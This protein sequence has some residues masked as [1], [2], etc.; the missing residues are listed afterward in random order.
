MKK[1]TLLLAILSC[2]LTF[3]Q[4]KTFNYNQKLTYTLDLQRED[5]KDIDYNVKLIN[6]YSNESLFGSLELQSPWIESSKESFISLNN[7][8]YDVESNSIENIITI[9]SNYNA[10]E[11]PKEDAKPYSTSFFGDIDKVSP[12]NTTST[13]NNYTC[14]N[15]DIVYKQTVTDEGYSFEKGKD[16]IC[17]DEKNAI[18]NINFLLP[19]HNLKG[20]LVFLKNEGNGITLNLSNIEKTNVTLT[21]DEKGETE[22]Y[23]VNIEKAKKEYEDLL[24]S[25][26]A[27]TE[28]TDLTM[29]DYPYVE[30]NT[31]QHPFCN[32][33]T[34]YSD[35]EN[36]PDAIYQIYNES[37]SELYNENLDYKKYMKSAKKLINEKINFYQ[38]MDLIT[39][40]E[41]KLIQ[42]VNKKLF[43]D[44]ESFKITKVESP[45]VD[46]NLYDTA[47]PVESYPEEAIAGE[48]YE[49]NYKSVN[50]DPISLAMEATDIYK[51]YIPNYCKKLEVPAFTNKEFSLHVKN[52]FGQICDLYAIP[53]D[54][55]VAIKETIDSMR[56]SFLKI[57]ELKEKQTKQDQTLFDQYINNLD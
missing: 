4:Q 7:R 28:A 21:F 3:A 24:N 39:K 13:Y 44:A 45:V 10:W 48:I 47:E 41:K 46:P 17:V 1:Y 56:K 36:A 22:R 40:D 2:S 50:I 55:N 33:H 30:S 34:Y 32:F 25:T 19:N 29:E 31:Y 6:Y 23:F 12:L 57:N 15:Y 8:L 42:N 14:K 18:N 49:S 52:Y 38:A 16:I 26:E 54:G 37:C 51:D 27:A 11:E 53:Y 5:T 35:L 20:L 43:K 9:K